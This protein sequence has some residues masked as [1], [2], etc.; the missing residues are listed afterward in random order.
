MINGALQWDNDV[1]TNEIDL[2][3]EQLAHFTANIML[4]SG[5][6]KKSTKLERIKESLYIPLRDREAYEKKYG[7]SKGKPKRSHKDAPADKVDELK[8]KFNL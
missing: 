7:Q 8:K 3:F 2:W 6:Y 5:N 4:S 1:K